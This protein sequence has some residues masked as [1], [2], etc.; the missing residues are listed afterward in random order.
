M[1]VLTPASGGMAG[2]VLHCT[3]IKGLSAQPWDTPDLGPPL[4]WLSFL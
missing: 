4:T 3:A 1:A 2:G